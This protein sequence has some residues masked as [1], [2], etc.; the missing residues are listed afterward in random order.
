MKARNHP[1]P[2]DPI[3]SR[4]IWHPGFFKYAPAN[5]HLLL[6]GIPEVAREPESPLCV[7][8]E[9]LPPA[10]LPPEP[11]S[12]GFVGVVIRELVFGVIRLDERFVRCLAVVQATH[13]PFDDVVVDAQ[14]G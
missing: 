10:Q 8:A 1:P 6:D 14:V 3:H 9:V 5:E 7:P 2:D 11:S 12:S 4:A 13:L